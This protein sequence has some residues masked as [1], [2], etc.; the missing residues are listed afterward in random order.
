MPSPW[1]GTIWIDPA[2]TV[3]TTIT[4]SATDGQVPIAVPFDPIFLGVS[5][6]MQ[7]LVVDAGAAQ[8]FSF[9]DALTF[10]IGQ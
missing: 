1:G 4:M 8:G 6:F 3:T 2:T 9:T 10:T 7:V 5:Y